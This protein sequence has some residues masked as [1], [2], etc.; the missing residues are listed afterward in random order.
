MLVRQASNRRTQRR[1]VGLD[2]AAVRVD[3]TFNVGGSQLA[4][5][6]ERR[7]QGSQG[8]T[9]VR[10]AIHNFDEDRLHARRRYQK[11]T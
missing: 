11:R 6:D 7:L 4:G 8:G 2:V 3:E 9:H 1:E 5:V 10:K